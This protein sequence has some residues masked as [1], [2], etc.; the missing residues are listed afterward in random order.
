MGSL[1]PVS[2]GST[3]RLLQKLAQI[4]Q[5][6]SLEAAREETIPARVAT[7]AAQR[8][9]R[10]ASRAAGVLSARMRSVGS[11]IQ[12]VREVP[13]RLGARDENNRQPW[14]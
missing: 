6:L 12:S 11:G 10:K 2:Q 3:R 7:C 14:R 4:V 8:S 9:Q 1:I 13:H 5:V